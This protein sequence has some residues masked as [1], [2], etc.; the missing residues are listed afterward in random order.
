MMSDEEN[1]PL[2]AVV[3]FLPRKVDELNDIDLV[4]YSWISTKKHLYCWYPEPDEYDEI[5]GWLESLRK[6]KKS[7]TQFPIEIVCI[8]HNLEQGK[9]RAERPKKT[10]KVESTDCDNPDKAT[11][12]IVQIFRGKSLKKQLDDV[13]P[14]S[15]RSSHIK[16]P[17]KSIQKCVQPQDSIRT[18][19]SISLKDALPLSNIEMIRNEL[20]QHSEIINEKLDVM[21]ASI[22]YDL[23]K[24]FEDLKKYLIAHQSGSAPPVTNLSTASEGFKSILPADDLESFESFEN[25]LTKTAAKDKLKNYYQVLSFGETDLTKCISKMMSA[26]ITKSIQ[27][28]YSGSGE[29]IHGSA[30]KSFSNTLASTNTFTC[31]QDII[32][33]KFSNSQ[34]SKSIPGKAEKWLAGAKDRYGGR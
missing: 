32:F 31:L 30:K 11:E 9:R 12:N 17:E 10:A 25:S 5:N 15:K 27:L 6:P 13:Q 7:W 22:S 34:E 14:T 23:E 4:P 20:K 3:L 18:R 29:S 16:P 2:Y 33:E 1:R 28:L 26:T 8:A 24:K 21:K 19:D